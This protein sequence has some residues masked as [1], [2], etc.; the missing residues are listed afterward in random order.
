MPTG[1]PHL[2]YLETYGPDSNCTLTPGPDY[3]LPAYSVYQYR[4]SI[5]ANAAFL[6]LFFLA[7]SIH[8]VMGYIY[9]T[10]TF[11]Q[12]MFWG[13]VSEMI[14][15]GGRI[16][17]YENP[18]SFTG[19]LMQIICI[20]LGPTFFTAAIYLTLSKMYALEAFVKVLNQLT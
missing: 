19:F 9:R 4:P 10:W 8:I 6:A 1:D 15:Y 12:V 11:A 14:G 3:C 18:F 5:G 13:C 16:M 2:R 20:T 7:M 17:L